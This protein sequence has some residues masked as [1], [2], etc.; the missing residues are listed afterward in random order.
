MDVDVLEEA[1]LAE[2]HEYQLLDEPA[3]EEL[4]AVVRLA[5]FVAGVP[6]AT[7]NLID[8]NR[9]CQ[10]TTFG[11]EGADTARDDSMCAIRFRDGVLVHVPDASLDPVYKH[12]PW[13]TGQLA[14]VR[15]YASA[16]LVTPRGHALGSLCV[17]DSITGRLT[18]DQVTRLE[19][20]A[21]IAV[22]LFERRRQARM[23]LHLAAEAQEQRELA[24]LALRQAESQQE[25]TDAVLETIDVAVVAAD[26]DGRLTLFNR[27]ARDWHGL[28]ADPTVAPD[29]QAARYSLF[30]ADGVTPLTA[31]EIPLHQARHDGKVTGQEIVIAPPER[32]ATR[33][34]VAGRAMTRLDGSSI[35]A[36]VAMTDVTAERA[37]Q[38]ALEAAH[39]ELNVRN[40]ELERSN[41]ELEQFA[42]VAS[43]DLSQP[44]M[45]IGGYLEL[46]GEAYEEVLDSQAMRWI[47]VARN[48]VDRMSALITALLTYAQ[49]GGA[50][51]VRRPSDTGDIAQQVVDDLDDAI[52]GSGA[53]VTIRRPMPAADCDPTLVRQLLQNLVANAIKY[54]DPDRPCRVEV[55]GGEDGPGWAFAVA[56]N[57]PGVPAD[58]RDHVFRM[59]TALEPGGSA[60]S[61]RGH[62][63]GLA[64][65]QR[66][67][68]RHGGRIWI[69]ETPGGGATVRFTITRTGAGHGPD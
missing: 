1:R 12:N 44:L 16:P 14:D 24:E 66:I 63:I 7:L 21:A 29:D 53:V 6:T 31:D 25:F 26:A 50:E 8:A 38:A 69:E 58:R 17:F 39:A 9:Q 57:G 11:F 33:A 4:E 59:F 3:D 36:V 45:A 15:F 55:R 65:C 37:Q 49:A 54:R 41:D 19:D 27:A 62:G 46:L 30:A 32:P 60:R 51:V 18:R 40:E 42:A 10:L 56:D 48:G 47:G 52:R 64:T 22:A 5:A 68:E 35:G 13:V 61:E 23:N 43:H 34:R 2:L 28:D 67:V 20:L